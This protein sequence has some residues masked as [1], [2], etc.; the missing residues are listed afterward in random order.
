MGKTRDLGSDQIHIE[1]P[2]GCRWIQ[3]EGTFH[4]LIKERFPNIMTESQID[5]AASQRKVLNAPKSV[6]VD[7]VL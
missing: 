2:R 1:V 5:T 7:A 4:L 3:R 6:A